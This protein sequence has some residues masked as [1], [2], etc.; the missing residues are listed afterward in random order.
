MTLAQRLSSASLEVGEEPVERRLRGGF[1]LGH[2]V[3]F[4]PLAAAA[5]EDLRPVDHVVDDLVAGRF[6]RRHA[7]GHGVAG[8]AAFG[9]GGRALE[10]QR[11]L[12]G[13]V[14]D[15]GLLEVVGAGLGDVDVDD[16]A[17]AA[18]GAG[19]VDDGAFLLAPAV[20]DPHGDVGSAGRRRFAAEVDQQLPR[21]L[22]LAL[23][24]LDALERVAAGGAD[25][26][27]ALAGQRGQVAVQPRLAVA[28]LAVPLAALAGLE[29]VF[30]VDL[31]QQRALVLHG[32]AEPRRPLRLRR[33]IGQQLQD[34][35]DVLAEFASRRWPG[36]RPSG[37]PASPASRGRRCRPR[38]RAAACGSGRSGRKAAGRAGRRGVPS[39]RLRIVSSIS[40][41]RMPVLR[42]V[43]ADLLDR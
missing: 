1:D 29:A 31:D 28:E 11:G 34:A 21:L 17:V 2:E 20:A 14:L 26:R 13:L 38:P 39:S 3:Q 24:E 6:G 32:L 12:G 7:R 19:I 16:R 9:R 8:L 5:L 37:R 30:A 36:R 18:G 15:D 43:R 40:R 23:R 33:R 42:Q 41:S 25:E 22:A 10:L 35:R 27:A 4:V